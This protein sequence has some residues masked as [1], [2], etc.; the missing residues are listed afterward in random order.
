[1]LGSPL[2]TAIWSPNW[3][4]VLG[5]T[6]TPRVRLQVAILGALI[7]NPRPLTDII[8]SLHAQMK[9]W[10]SFYNVVSPCESLRR[11]RPWGTGQVLRGLRD[12]KIHSFLI[13]SAP[14]L[15]MLAGRYEIQA[16]S[17]QIRSRWQAYSVAS[18]FGED[19]L[20]FNFPNSRSCNTHTHTHTY[21]SCTK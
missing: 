15:A 6:S 16:V 19:F 1:M 7:Y 14:W 20:H 18:E 13:S 5:C 12:S 21:M 2:L 17:R 4:K 3:E 11:F 8:F 9:L 10:F